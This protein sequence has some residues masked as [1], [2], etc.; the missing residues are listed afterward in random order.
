[1]T[2]DDIA[3]TEAPRTRRAQAKVERRR[4][5]IETGAHDIE[6]SVGLAHL[7]PADHDDPLVVAGV[8]RPHHRNDIGRD[9]GITWAR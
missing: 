3:T 8:D 6:Q 4:A 5:L 1:M 9:R 7:G 2:Q